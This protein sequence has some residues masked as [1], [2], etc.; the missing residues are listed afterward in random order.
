MLRN[1]NRYKKFDFFNEIIY[2][3]DDIRKKNYCDYTLGIT[4][5]KSDDLGISLK[6]TNILNKAKESQYFALNPDTFQQDTPLSISPIDQS[7]I[8]SL[9]YTF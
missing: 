6:G 3:R 7:I 8:L 2:Y 5:H 1:F 4:Y 9:E